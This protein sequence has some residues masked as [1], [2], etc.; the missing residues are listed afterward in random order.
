MHGCSGAWLCLLFVKMSGQRWAALRNMSDLLHPVWPAPCPLRRSRITSPPLSTAVTPSPGCCTRKTQPSSGVAAAGWV[1]P[2]GSKCCCCC[3]C[4][5]MQHLRAAPARHTGPAKHRASGALC[6]ASP[7]A[8]SWNLLNEPRCKYCGPE[9]V[10]SWFGEIAAHLKVSESSRATGWLFS[11]AA[12]MLRAF[13]PAQPF[14]CPHASNSPCCD[15]LCRA[16][17]AAAVPAERGPQPSG[18]HWGGGLL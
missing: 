15:A 3:C 7:P 5:P 6:P 2:H 18:D 8:R 11:G 4:R 1:Q 12:G 16:A 14:A 13:V 17:A 9:A 10:D